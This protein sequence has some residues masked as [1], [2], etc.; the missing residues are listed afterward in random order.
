MTIPPHVSINLPGT[1]AAVLL[2]GHKRQE[3]VGEFFR[4]EK[5]N[6]AYAW[7]RASFHQL[8]PD[9][10]SALA[11]LV[12]EPNNPE[13]ANA[14]AIYVGSMLVGYLPRN[15]AAH[16]APTLATLRQQLGAPA[17]CTA[18]FERLSDDGVRDVWL[19]L[20]TSI[21]PTRRRRD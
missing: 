13:D 7:A 11:L 4:W 21:N 15:A 8:D 19:M 10:A 6:A 14:V 16:W 3:V 9:E 1:G 2:I 5:V 17:C 18:R 20:P 12:L